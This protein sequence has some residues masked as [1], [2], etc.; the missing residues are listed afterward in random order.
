MASSLLF[1]RAKMSTATTGTGTITL[2]S[3]VS[4]FDS[5]ANAGVAN[6]NQVS[7]LIEDGSNWEYGTGTYTSSGTTLTRTVIRSSSGTSAI[8]L[9]GAAQVSLTALSQ[10]L[11]T[12]DGSQTLT[13]KTISSAVSVAT[14]DGTLYPLISAATQTPGA[15]SA[16]DF[17]SIPSW[18]TR[19]IINFSGISHTAGDQTL[20]RLGTGTA[21][22]PNFAATGY[23]SS[24]GIYS[25]S[26]TS[27]SSSTTGFVCRNSNAT[28][29][30]SGHMIIVHMGSNLW[31]S[32]HNGKFLTTQ[33][34][35]GG[36]NVTLGGTLTQ[37]RVT[38]DGAST[39]DAGSISLTYE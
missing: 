30:F 2:G 34:G 3:A 25:G 4:G 36:G 23:V 20:V 26:A 27:L 32:S 19:I 16:V 1:N 5:F 11:A 29:L 15:V 38:N 13:N 21:G 31:V 24:G 33:V 7:Y 14:T 17:N 35:N 10:D 22:S 28:Y 6:S 9:S 12:L 39:F 37:V 18:V 8:S